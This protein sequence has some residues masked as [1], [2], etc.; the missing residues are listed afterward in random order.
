MNYF[1]AQLYTM[2]NIRYIPVVSVSSYDDAL[3]QYCL[4][5]HNCVKCVYGASRNNFV[6]GEGDPNADIMFI[7]EGPGADEDAQGRPFVGRAGQLLTKVIE[8]EGLPR[9]SVY[10]ANIVKCRPFNNEDPCEEAVKECLPY[11]HHQISLVRPKVIVTLGKVPGRI[12]FHQKDIKITAEHGKLTE[13]NGITVL[14]AYHPSF[15]VRNNGGPR[16]EEFRVDIRKA[17]ELAQKG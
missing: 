5:I 3:S 1:A 4:A 17:M 13:Y 7:G 2:N 16:L 8:S 15:I 14:M 6:F 9:R 12:F 10:I 11:L